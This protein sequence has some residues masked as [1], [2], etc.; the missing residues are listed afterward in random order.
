MVDKTDI[1]ILAPLGENIRTHRKKSGL[2]QGHLARL[3][4]IDQSDISKIEK[5]QINLSYTTLNKLAFALGV[6][7]KVLVDY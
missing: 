1:E 6:K 4:G 3:S 5:G 7:L 2:T